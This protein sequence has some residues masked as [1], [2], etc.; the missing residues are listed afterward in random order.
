[1]PILATHFVTADPRLSQSAK[2]HTSH[3]GHLPEEQKL[4]YFF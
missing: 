3:P 2:H 1:M 4:S